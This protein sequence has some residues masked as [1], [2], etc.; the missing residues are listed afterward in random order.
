MAAS[1]DLLRSYGDVAAV[2]DVV[3][4]ALT[5]LTANEDY[6]QNLLGSTQALNT[7][8][9]Y[10]TDT[11][12]TAAT[13][14]VAEDAD[15]TMIARTTPS[16][17][18][19]V[20]ENFAIPFT[21]TRVQS[22][23]QKY[24]GE[25]ELERQ[26]SKGLKEFADAVEFDLVRSTL[27]SGQSGVVPKLSGILEAISQSTNYTAHNSGTV[28]SASVLQGLMLNNW[29]VSNGETA[30]D[31]FVGSVL[32]NYT[33]NFTQKTYT[34]ING[35]QTSVVN[36]VNVYQSSAGVVRVHTH[37]F[38]KQSGDTTSRAL[39]IRPES[40]KMAWLIKPYV[41]TGL[42]RLGPYDVRTVAGSATLEVRAKTSNW[43]A[44]GFLSS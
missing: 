18:S 4:N 5:Y 12:R 36:M 42:A 10:L 33:D 24:T 16:R 13:A 44:I 29:S 17:Q 6:I 11:Y 34:V 22:A 41:D 14:A 38:I 39:A 31:L 2:D 9:T 23:T 26:T 25:N 40:L 28:W 7:T 15:Y 20:V 3:R 19:N 30:T 35:D 1:A 32:R 21:V 43:F 8:H 27:V 37:R